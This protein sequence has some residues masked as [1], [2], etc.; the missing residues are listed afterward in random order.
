MTDPLTGLGNRRR[1]MHDL[2]DLLTCDLTAG[3]GIA[4][5]DLDGF[6]AFNDAFGHPAGD[7]LLGRLGP[8]LQQTCDG[9]GCAYRLGGDEFCVVARPGDTDLHDLAERARRALTEHGPGYA[10][11]ASCGHLELTRDRD[12][13]E[14]L[15]EVDARL[16][17]DKWRRTAGRRSSAAVGAT[18]S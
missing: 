14:T 13:V 5:F 1:L 4:M 17:S 7:A 11:G 3:A 8:R 16:Y 18:G 10:V 15:R 12:L 9:V 2:E 6:K